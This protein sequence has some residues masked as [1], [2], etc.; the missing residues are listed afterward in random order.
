M[1][2]AVLVSI[3]TGIFSIIGGGIGLFGIWLTRRDV[4]TVR[5]EN[6]QQHASAQEERE[7]SFTQLQESHAKLLDKVDLVHKDVQTV[8][9]TVAVIGWKLEDHIKSPH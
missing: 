8:G 5:R 3:V 1:S 7:E 6:A 2:D 9:D 4:H